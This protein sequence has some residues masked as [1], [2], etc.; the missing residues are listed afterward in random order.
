MS[1]RKLVSIVPVSAH[2]LGD[3]LG[4][5]RPCGWWRKHIVF[6]RKNGTFVVRVTCMS[7]NNGRELVRPIPI[8]ADHE[9]CKRKQHALRKREGDKMYHKNDPCGE[10]AA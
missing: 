1:K 6:K 5:C 9:T 3:M 2:E 7:V 8:T 10:V 4:G